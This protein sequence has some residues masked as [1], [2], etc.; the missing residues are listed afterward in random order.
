MPAPKPSKP[1][2]SSIPLNTWLIHRHS[3]NLF[4]VV[5]IHALHVVTSSDDLGTGSQMTGFANRFI[6]EE[7]IR[8]KTV[9]IDPR[10]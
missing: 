6:L 5:R 7:Q 3:H 8:R 10:G 9:I 1:V 2:N 4:K